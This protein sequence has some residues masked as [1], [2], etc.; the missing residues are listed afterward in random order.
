MQ[1]SKDEAGSRKDRKEGR[2]TAKAIVSESRPARLGLVGVEIRLMFSMKRS[3]YKKGHLALRDLELVGS[4]L[5]LLED[6]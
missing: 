6:H 5:A 1:L 3:S 4:A 2:L